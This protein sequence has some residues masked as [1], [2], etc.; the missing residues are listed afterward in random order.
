M[1]D[2]LFASSP[3]RDFP[4]GQ[5]DS[6]LTEQLGSPL[7]KSSL[8]TSWKARHNCDSFRGQASGIDVRTRRAS[9]AE[10]TRPS[11]EAGTRARSPPRGVSRGGDRGGG[12]RPTRRSPVEED[13]RPP[14]RSR[15]RGCRCR[16]P[17]GRRTASRALA[18]ARCSA[19]A[20]LAPL[21]RRARSRP[22]QGPGAVLAG[23]PRRGAAPETHRPSFLTWAGGL[24]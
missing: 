20:S 15:E 14:G 13:E 17:P 24:G 8:G 16:S 7:F 2:N 18:G 12:S 10:L 1:N 5:A 21:E 3:S 9:Q 23:Q 19:A 4:A 11:W 22:R 6:A